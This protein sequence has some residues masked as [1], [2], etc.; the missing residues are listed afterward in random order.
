MYDQEMWANEWDR[1]F[2]M[3]DTPTPAAVTQQPKPSTLRQTAYDSS[4][5][6]AALTEAVKAHNTR[7]AA[8]TQRLETE[9]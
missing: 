8:R 2:A 7:V 4:L 6:D 3:H 1:L 5:W 9:E